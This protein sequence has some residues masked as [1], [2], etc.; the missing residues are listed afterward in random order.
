MPRLQAMVLAARN[1]G[2]A[3]SEKIRIINAHGTTNEPWVQ[4][5][6]PGCGR[7]HSINNTWTFNGDMERPTIT[8]SVKVTWPQGKGKPDRICHSFV[9]DGKIQFLSD[10]THSL[11]GQTV[12]LDEF[13][14]TDTGVRCGYLADGRSR[15][16]QCSKAAIY[17]NAE[18]ARCNVHGGH[19]DYTER[20]DG[21]VWIP[22]G[23]EAK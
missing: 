21:T 14:L 6:C 5:M 19:H 1:G 8:P 23:E 3:M 9:T 18:L 4:F 2:E 7:T 13:P 20:W 11:A 10:C 22:S 12:D 16:T 17:R 15:Y